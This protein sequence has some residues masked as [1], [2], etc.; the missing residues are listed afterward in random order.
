MSLDQGE[1]MRSAA[2][3]VA[4]EASLLIGHRA[5]QA[6]P[7]HLGEADDGVQR[8]PQLVGH[9]GEEFGLHAARFF[10]LDVFLLQRLLEAFQLRHV[11][12]R[13]EHALQAPIAVV[14]GGRVVGHH[15]ERAIPGARGELVVG[16]FAFRSARG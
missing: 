3:D 5:D 8:G 4:D 14:E 15:G 9:V 11:A 7:E 16:D 6:V 10:Q 2:E 13:G 12:R 1:Q